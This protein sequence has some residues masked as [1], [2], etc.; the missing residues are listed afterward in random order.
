M[1]ALATEM[2]GIRNEYSDKRLKVIFD[3][4]STENTAFFVGMI[5]RVEDQKSVFQCD[6]VQISVYHR[7]IIAIYTTEAP[8]TKGTH[9]TGEMRIL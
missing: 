6:G 9:P 8:L 7:N 2:R 4:T 3:D 1:A 5:H